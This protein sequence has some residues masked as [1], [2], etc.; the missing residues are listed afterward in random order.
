MTFIEERLC[1]AALFDATAAI[2]VC[3]QKPSQGTPSF[4][5]G[6]QSFG[7]MPTRFVAAAGKKNNQRWCESALFPNRSQLRENLD[8]QSGD[9]PGEMGRDHSIL[10]PM[11]RPLPAIVLRSSVG[12]TVI[13]T[14]KR[15]L[16]QPNSHR[17]VFIKG[18]ILRSQQNVHIHEKH[19]PNAKK[20]V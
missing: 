18:R 14:L 1:L 13:K 11:Q 9:Y 5:V 3:V 15:L 19:S 16:F 7:V 8:N 20:S 4:E 10:G 12:M 2:Y 6:N 17:A